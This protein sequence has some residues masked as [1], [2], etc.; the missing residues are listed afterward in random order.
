MFQGL[1]LDRNTFEGSDENQIQEASL[2]SFDNITLAFCKI[3][4]IKEDT[5]YNLNTVKRL[6]L[7]NNKQSEL[8]AN[9]FLGCDQLEQLSLSSNQVHSLVQAQFAPLD[10]LRTLDLSNNILSFIHADAFKNLGSSMQVI[11]L[12][13]NQLQTLSEVSL[14][15]MAG[16]QVRVHVIF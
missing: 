14:L 16:L 7:S 13:N 12:Q 10:S 4:F 8:P 2:K 15:P 9:S 11:N 3:H 1:I 6:N 5:F